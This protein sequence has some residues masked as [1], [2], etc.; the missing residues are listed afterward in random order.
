[1]ENANPQPDAG[2]RL[3]LLLK[4]AGYRTTRIDA[5][6][7]AIRSGGRTREWT[8]VA[9]TANGWLHLYT[10][11][12]ALPAEAGLR[13]RALETAMSINSCMPLMKFVANGGLILELDYRLEHVDATTLG[14]L[15]GLLI[16]NAE[17]WYP[18][19]FRVVTGDD[20]LEALTPR[21]LP[22][23]AKG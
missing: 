21:A 8:I 15:I 20:V 18:K 3:R 4:T 1:M 12:C 22:S 5:A 6:K 7:R 13:L 2:Q 9:H 14:H 23:A 17:E 10:A 19:I 16:A 11:V